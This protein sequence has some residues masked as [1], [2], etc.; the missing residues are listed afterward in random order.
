MVI[1]TAH[2]LIEQNKGQIFSVE[3]FK[4]D[5][6]LRK[7]RA[8]LGVKKGLKG[9]GLRFDPLAKGLLPVY[10]MDKKGYRMV[11]IR[12]IQQLKINKQTYRFVAE[13]KPRQ[14]IGVTRLPE[15]EQWLVTVFS[16][17]TAK[18]GC[19]TFGQESVK[20]VYELLGRIFKKGQENG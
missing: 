4:K 15:G 8:R 17:G 13:G 3:F 20:N 14:R 6:T 1:N 11:T 16:D 9:V 2:S 10:D 19:T 5:G 12:N 7:M 18:V